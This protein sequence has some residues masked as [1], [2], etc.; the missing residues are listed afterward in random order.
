MRKLALIACLAVAG[1]VNVGCYRPSWPMNPTISEPEK[2][3]R[4]MAKAL[5]IADGKCAENTDDEAEL[6]RCERQYIE[7]KALLET[8]GKE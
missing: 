4:Y 5:K 2:E 6:I 3:L 8:L 1:L 7:L